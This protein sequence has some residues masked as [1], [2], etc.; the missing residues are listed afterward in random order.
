MTSSVEHRMWSFHNFN[1]EVTS[2]T[3]AKT[4]FTLPQP[5]ELVTS[6]AMTPNVTIVD[7]AA[8]S[9]ARRRCRRAQSSRR[10]GSVTASFRVVLSVSSRPAWGP[11]SARSTTCPAICSLAR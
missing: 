9:E 1:K 10:V 3:T 8:M 2:R 5:L 6:Q 7:T 4:N 11:W